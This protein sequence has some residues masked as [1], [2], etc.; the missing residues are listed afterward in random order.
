MIAILTDTNTPS[1]SAASHLGL[2]CIF[3]LFV[4]PF[5]AEAL[6]KCKENLVENSLNTGMNTRRHY[7][8]LQQSSN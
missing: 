4:A 3:R 1:A 7:D 6:L 5:P 2:M 8:V